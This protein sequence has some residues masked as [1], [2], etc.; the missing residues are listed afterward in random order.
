LK[1]TKISERKS[2]KSVEGKRGL[3]NLKCWKVWR[4]QTKEMRQKKKFYTTARGIKVSFQPTTSICEDRDNNLIA[5][6]PLML[7][8]WKQHFYDTLNN[9]DDMQIREK[10][11]CQGPEVQIEL[12]TKDKVWEIMTL[13]K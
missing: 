10:V 5:N 4:K 6:D 3:I 9:K 7:E 11:I 8:K 13:K 2:R 1:I 12:P